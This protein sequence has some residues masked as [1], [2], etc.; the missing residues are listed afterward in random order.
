MKSQLVIILAIWGGLL[1][2]VLQFG[3]GADQDA[4]AHQ[5]ISVCGAWGCGPPVE[6][7]ASWHGFWIVFVALPVGLL[8]RSWPARRLKAVGIGLTGAGVLGLVAVVAYE[9]ATWLPEASGDLSSYFV[10]RCFFAVATLTDIPLIPT[11]IGGIAFWIGGTVKSR[12]RATAETAS[13][14]AEETPPP[15]GSHNAEPEATH[16]AG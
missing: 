10:Q 14:E 15:A 1:W 2:G 5:G 7:L 16:V 6:A 4:H 13:H 9:A 12:K 8:I 11:T 3:G